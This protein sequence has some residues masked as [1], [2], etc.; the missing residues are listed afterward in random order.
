MK[1][2]IIAALLILSLVSCRKEI[3]KPT[4]DPNPEIIKGKITESIDVDGTTREYIAYIP[5]KY[6]GLEPVPL[7]FAFH[8]FGGNMSSSYENSQFHKIA[9][10]ENFIV[11][12]PNGISNK[13][14]AVSSQSNID[15]TFVETMIEHFKESY[16]IES[17][18]IYSSGMSNGAYFSFLLACELSDKIAGI[19]AVAGLMFK[20][21]FTNCDPSSSMPIIQIHGTKDEL[22]DYNNVEE[23]LNF[24]INHN[25]TDETPIITDI[26]DTDTSD[27]STIKKYSYKNGLDQVEIDHLKIIG[28]THDWPGYQ[29]NM[30]INASETIWN[31]LK[32]YD[33]NGKIE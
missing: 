2:R 19:G 25:M 14:N 24:W 18:Q 9:E 4:V 13:W 1:V 15:L 12:H 28:G 5:E 10:K 20:P 31:F 8:G 32:N 21:V 23:V 11:V 6:T 16:N 26:P 30:D 17:K 29:G 33:I 3:D 27:G 7:V 22:V